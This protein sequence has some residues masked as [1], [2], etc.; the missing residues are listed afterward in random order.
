MVRLC[1]CMSWMLLAAR[2]CHQPAT[3][4]PAAAGGESEPLFVEFEGSNIAPSP[5]SESE[6]VSPEIYIR[7]GQMDGSMLDAYYLDVTE[8][9]NAAYSECVAGGRCSPAKD[10]AW[11]RGC[12]AGDEGRLPDLPINCVSRAQAIAYCEWVGKRLPTGDELKWEA[13]GG[14]ENRFYPWGESKPNCTHGNF[15]VIDD[16][17]GYDKWCGKGVEPVGSYPSGASVHG[18]LDLEGNVSEWVSDTGYRSVCTGGISYRSMITFDRGYRIF[19]R[20]SD[21]GAP[22]IGIRCARDGE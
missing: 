11:A 22:T 4:P 6:F 13:K 1:L 3:P 18:V 16:S 14:E 7:G 12:I 8:T 5:R 10:G 17:S 2:G 19:S 9:T 15:G 21:K 20:R